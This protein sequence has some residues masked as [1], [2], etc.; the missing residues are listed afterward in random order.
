MSFKASSTQLGLGLVVVGALAF[1][2]VN[3][4]L[5]M[6]VSARILTWASLVDLVPVKCYKYYQ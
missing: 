6:D 4:G 1:H 3:P 5:N 2:A